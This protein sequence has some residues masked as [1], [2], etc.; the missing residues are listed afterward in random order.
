MIQLAIF[1]VKSGWMQCCQNFRAPNPGKSG[2]SPA[3]SNFEVAQF[4]SSNLR[5][6]FPKFGCFPALKDSKSPNWAENNSNVDFRVKWI[7]HL[8]ALQEML[9]PQ[10]DE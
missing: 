5:A 8:I 3:V 2:F 7:I 4:L 1:K 10:I 9:I 6:Q